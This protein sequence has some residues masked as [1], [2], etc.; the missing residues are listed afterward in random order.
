MMNSRNFASWPDYSKI[1]VH[2]GQLA[3]EVRA[4]EQK[5]GEAAMQLPKAFVENNFEGSP[6]ASITAYLNRRRKRA[7]Q[8]EEQRREEERKEQAII[9]SRKAYDGNPEVDDSIYLKK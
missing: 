6:P 3:E 5:A 8:D 2:L 9:A 1:M 7:L 4:K